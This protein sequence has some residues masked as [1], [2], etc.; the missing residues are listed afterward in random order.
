MKKDNFLISEKWGVV[1][2]SL[3]DE[4]AG[5]LIKAIY[6]IRENPNYQMEDP[7]LTAIFELMKDFIIENERKYQ[8]KCEKMAANGKIKKPKESIDSKSKQLLPKENKEDQIE[9]DNSLSLSYSIKEIIDYLNLKTGKSFRASSKTTKEHI[10]ARLSEGF[11]VDDFKRVIDHKT[12]QWLNDAKMSEYLRPETLFCSKFESYLQSAP[13][14][15]NETMKPKPP[16]NR[17]K[18]D[19][20]DFDTMIKFRDLGYMIDDDGYWIDKDGKWITEDTA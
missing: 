17:I 18:Y 11:T 12:E 15:K 4:K 20:D 3:P 2:K 5:Q 9:S 16:D 10:N 6:E 13:K 19:S 1:F 7:V 14:P 8:E